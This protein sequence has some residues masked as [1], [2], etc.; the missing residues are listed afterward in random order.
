MNKLHRNVAAQISGTDPSRI[1]GSGR[2]PG[3][4]SLS[5]KGLR[6]SGEAPKIVAVILKSKVWGRNVVVFVVLGV[7]Q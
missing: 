6:S 3:V 2:K 5:E 4:F 1:R 7:E